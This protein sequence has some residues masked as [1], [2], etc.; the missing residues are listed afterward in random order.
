MAIVGAVGAGGVDA[1]VDADVVAA[2]IPG[3]EDG[4]MAARSGLGLRAQ[5]PSRTMAPIT[6]SANG[7]RAGMAVAE[8]GD[9]ASWTRMWRQGVRMVAWQECRDS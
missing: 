9:M 2:W 1:A 5:A 3:V 7:W 6:A 4:C 8:R